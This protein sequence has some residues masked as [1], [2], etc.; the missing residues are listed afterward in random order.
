MPR[1]NQSIFGQNIFG[2][3]IFGRIL[4]KRFALHASHF[5]IF[6]LI[7][8]S[9]GAR[10]RAAAVPAADV[11][12]FEA[13]AREFARRVAG[14]FPAGM[15]VGVEVRNR[16]ALS[17]TDVA[18]VRAA[19]VDELSARGLRVAPAAADSADVTDSATVTL[20][21]NAEGYLWVAEIRQSDRSSVMLAAV[22][23]PSA[24][25]SAEFSGI[26]LRS[27]LVWS[28]PEHVLAAAA[29]PPAAS[30]PSSVASSSAAIGAPDLLL[31]VTDGVTASV[32]DGQHTFRI[33]LPPSGDALRDAQ[34]TLAWTAG[35]LIASA[36]GQTCTLRVPLA[37]SQPQCRADDGPR[38]A[39][40]GSASQIGSQ[41]AELP[42]ACGDTR[43]E[44][45]ATGT[46][47][48]TQPDSIRAYEMR[49]GAAAPVSP[50]LEFP[51]PVMSLQATTSLQMATSS[52]QTT[53]A[54][55]A[56]LGPSA[57]AVVRNLAAGDDEVYEISLV[58]GR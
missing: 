6:L 58:C 1:N 25:P 19:I 34:G 16:S 53:M 20:S 3:N 46:G 15:R 18:A 7:L 28:G 29:F 33:A 40:S 39:P 38:P 45:L 12:P 31:L 21:E 30:A 57:F 13:P 17:A 36:S 9:I 2:Q 48:Y 5:A 35:A 27:A 24:A 52:S 44:L 11:N 56:Q 23:R 54:S 42:A 49:S 4:L 32:I 26:T 22:S 37:V 50:A 14:S 47:D 55:P 10:A 51:G 8:F 41:R 43:G